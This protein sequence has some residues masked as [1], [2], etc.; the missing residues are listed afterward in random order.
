MILAC[1]DFAYGC[2]LGALIFILV[3][4]IQSEVRNYKRNR[5]LRP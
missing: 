4:L 3:L 1:S 5:N 2:A